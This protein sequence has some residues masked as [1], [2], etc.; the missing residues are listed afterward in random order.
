L[1][2]FLQ[3][4]I[5]H[6]ISLGLRY[7]IPVLGRSQTRN[8][9]LRAFSFRRPLIAQVLAWKVTLLFPRLRC[10]CH[11][12]RRRGSGRPICCHG[13]LSSLT[14]ATALIFRRQLKKITQ[15]LFQAK[16][17]PLVSEQNHVFRAEIVEPDDWRNNLHSAQKP[18]MSE[19]ACSQH[20]PAT[21]A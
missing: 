7:W 10:C 1:L 3:S 14:Q 6:D 9:G 16:R 12:R 18:S 19:T 4:R 8:V 20:L 15:S 5:D 13:I 17:F 2:L 11:S 21:F